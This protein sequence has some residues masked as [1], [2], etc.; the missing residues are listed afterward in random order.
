MRRSVP[1]RVPTAVRDP[2]PRGLRAEC[3]WQSDP[4]LGIGVITSSRMTRSRCC[5]GRGP[6]GRR[7]GSGGRS[8]PPSSGRVRRASAHRAVLARVFS[9]RRVLRTLAPM[10]N[11]PEQG[12]RA[13]TAFVSRAAD[14]SRRNGGSSA[15]ARRDRVQTRASFARRR[16]FEVQTAERYAQRASTDSSRGSRRCQHA[17]CSA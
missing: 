8:C 2:T 15:G 4:R 16:A 14:A 9:A 7:L 1:W 6:S 5:R 17:R 3:V 12:L 13:P 11:R 10:T